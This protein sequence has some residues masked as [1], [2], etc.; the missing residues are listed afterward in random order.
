MTTDIHGVQAWLD[1]YVEAWRS[2]DRAEIEALFTDDAVYYPEPYSEPLRGPAA[3]ADA[4]L[5][6]RDPDGSWRAD[7]HAIAAAGDTGVGMGT[8][9]YLRDDGAV[10][11]VYHNVFVLTFDQNDRCSEYRE[12]YMLQPRGRS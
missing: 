5:E 12:W 8:S 4:W 7:Y 11:R 2:Y 10:D 3:V 1:R 6:S 9:S